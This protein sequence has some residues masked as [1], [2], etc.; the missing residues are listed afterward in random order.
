MKFCKFLILLELLS[1]ATGETPLIYYSTHKCSDEFCRPMVMKNGSD[2]AVQGLKDPFSTMSTIWMLYDGERHR[3][4]DWDEFLNFGYSPDDVKLMR[5]EELESIPMGRPFLRFRGMDPVIQARGDSKI[6]VV[7]NGCREPS[8][9]EA[10]ISMG[11]SAVH[12]QRLPIFEIDPIP[13]VYHTTNDCA[14]VCCRPWNRCGDLD[15]ALRAWKESTVYVIKHGCRQPV[16]W[17]RL[18]NEGYSTQCI[19]NVTLLDLEAIPLAYRQPG[20]ILMRTITIINPKV[21][22]PSPLP[23]LI[24]PFRL[25]CRRLQILFR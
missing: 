25:K 17:Q 4:D 8:T 1:I 22:L 24:F 6:F 12:I 11:Y 14:D 9:I 19:N 21:D 15:P 5:A 3:V 16:N 7:R 20:D 18:V 2:I 10:V 23:E 13:L